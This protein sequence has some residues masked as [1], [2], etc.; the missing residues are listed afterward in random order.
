MTES[1]T[2][3]D[4]AAVWRVYQAVFADYPG[5]TA[6]R[7]AVWDKHSTRTGFRLAG[8]YAGRQL[9]G[10]A[11]GYTG[12]SGQWWTDNART[13]LKPEVAD[14]WLDGHFEVVTL[15]VL[16]QARRGGNGRGLMR[17]LLDG[18][19]H[20]RLLLMTT[21]DPADPARRLYESEGW[22]VLGP[23]IGE[24]TV[25]MGRRSLPLDSA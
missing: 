13:V 9:I 5:Y 18:L 17:A 22:A 6:W 21:A 8:A 12:E 3:A 23:G 25:I 19:P 24:D 2:E 15:G 10:F 11:Y 4:A 20:D 14:E 1:A 7:E 16:P